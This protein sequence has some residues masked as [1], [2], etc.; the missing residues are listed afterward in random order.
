M[1]AWKFLVAAVLLA[2]LP[3][4]AQSAVG[5]TAPSFAFSKS[6]NLASGYNDLEALNGR[7]VLLE[8][9]ATWCPPCVRNVPHMNDIQDAF[10]AGGLTII[11]CSDERASVIEGFI[12]SHGVRYPVVQSANA[13][14]LYRV[15][16]IPHAFLL[17]TAGKVVWEGHPAELTNADI[18]RI[19]GLK[20]QTSLMARPAETTEVPNAPASGIWFVVIGVLALV[21]VGALGWFWWKTGDH[22]R[23]PAVTSLIVP[24]VVAPPGAPPGATGP[25]SGAGGATAAPAT[26]QRP[27]SS[28]TV[29]PLL[30]D[31]GKGPSS[32]QTRSIKLTPSGRF[33]TVPYAPADDSATELMPEDSQDYSQGSAPPLQPS[34][35]PQPTRP[36]QF[37]PFNAG[38]RQV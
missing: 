3:L 21:M 4:C 6:W 20:A 31:V 28:T 17:S 2:A 37:R 5:R 24:P 35:P 16:G 27:A 8:F 7:P 1:S 23:K 15:S 9:W 30:T 34:P 33:P 32:G 14:N 36:V 12:K 13:G 11:A 18:E 22:G 26:S 29:A 25:T 10:S 19:L 38:G